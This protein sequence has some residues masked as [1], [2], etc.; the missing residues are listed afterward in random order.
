[1]SHGI[2]L[3]FNLQKAISANRKGQTQNK[4][5]RLTF[6]LIDIDLFFQVK[7][8]EASERIGGRVLTYRDPQN[9]WYADLGA[10]RIPSNHT[11]VN[12]FIEKFNLSLGRFEMYN[13]NT[14]YYV[15][16][17]LQKT[18]AVED[19]IDILN[20]HLNDEE[21]NLNSIDQIFERGIKPILDDNKAY[22]WDYVVEKYGHFSIKTYLDQSVLSPGAVKMFGVVSNERSLFSTSVLEAIR[23]STTINDQTVFHEIVGG[24][25]HLPNAFLSELQNDI[26]LNSPVV[27]IHQK[28]N[29]VTVGYQQKS[30]TG[31]EPGTVT[32]DYCIVTTTTKAALLIDYKPPLS[33]EK[34]DAFTE[35]HYDSST[36][37]YLYFSEAFWEEEGITGG[38][39]I[40]DG[41]TRYTYYPSHNTSSGGV[42]LASYTWGEDSVGWLSFTDEECKQ[43]A[44]KTL[45]FI[46]RK[47]L[48]QIYV[49]GVVKKW[50]EDEYSHG[51]FAL[52]NPTQEKELYKDLFRPEGRI[53]FAGEHTTLNH[54]WMEGAIASG[55]RSAVHI[56]IDCYD[57]AVVGGGPV[58]LAAAL[59]AA[60]FGKR[61]V[62]LDRNS[63]KNSRGSSNGMSRQF[64]VM[65]EEKLL[66]EFAKMSIKYWK[67]LEDWSGETLLH[68]DGYLFF[69]DPT[70]GKTTE[71]NFK[72][73]KKVCDELHLGCESITN[74]E[75][76]DRFHF[77]GIP[78]IWQGLY[79]K[80]SGQIDVNKTL[81]V[82]IDQAKKNN[83][84]LLENISVDEIKVQDDNIRLASDTN[85]FHAK[86]VIL[87]PGPY[88]NEVF[89]DIGFQINMDIWELSSFYYKMKDGIKYPTW[90]AFGGDKQNLY[91]GFPENGWERPGYTKVSPDFVKN[92]IKTPS[93]RT[94]KPDMDSFFKTTDFVRRYMPDVISSDHII[95][96][97]TCLATMVPDGGFVLDFAPPRFVQH[98]EDVI[99]FV[100]GWA[101]KFVPLF[102]KILADLAVTGKTSYN[103]TA[104]SVN[105]PG[106]LVSLHGGMTKSGNRD[107]CLIVVV[108]LCVA[109]TAIFIAITV[110]ICYCCKRRE[111]QNLDGVVVKQTTKV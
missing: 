90:F 85:F 64:R 59:F 1:M 72:E 57:V 109:L 43:M 106:I 19:N 58:G 18:K 7:I 87:V 28:D 54:A 78:N 63:F 2:S 33:Q 91:Y 75:V 46:H 100:A 93:E 48:S 41:V 50:S 37:I 77:P 62:V 13:P 39:T 53:F 4:T 80:H 89:A 22:G 88:A 34:F 42:V 5:V 47:D 74:Q 44:L 111:Y 81:D 14:Y 70:T 110:R 65:Y 66:A 15:N 36:K 31:T 86:K 71:G 11:L 98:S 102:G 69:G 27:S 40:T 20:F 6:F 99:I 96:N 95:E 3:R 16:K 101:F 79:H 94:N 61:V 55:L 68:Q 56:A 38:K 21:K 17:V 23:D 105:R 32:G 67:T 52:F 35:L 49:N 97:S 51:A 9:R 76:S 8:L 24:T 10:M 60:K 84:T 73:I 29:K 92:S 83:V 103:I 107:V 104:F 12:L 25:D 108:L 82:L 30:S 45:S 26:S